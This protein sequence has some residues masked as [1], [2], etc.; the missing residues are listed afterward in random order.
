MKYLVFVLAYFLMVD[1]C[2]GQCNMANWWYSFDKNGWSLC[3]STME[4]MTGMERN[5]NRGDNDKIYLLEKAKCCQA[6][7]PN[8]ESQSTCLIADWWVKLNS[9]NKWALC[10]EGY[11][12]QGLYRTSEEDWLSNIELGKCCKPDSLPNQY[13]KC[14]DKAITSSFD[15]KGLS[16]CDDGYYMAG[17]YKGSCNRLYCIETLKCCKMYKNID[18]CV[19]N[20]CKNG[21]TCVNFAGSYRCECK[22]GYTGNNCQT[23]INE[24]ALA[25]CQNGAKCVDL[26]GSY[27]CD[28]VAGYTGSNCETNVDEC[29]TDPCK[30]GATCVDLVGSYRCDCPAGYNGSNCE[31]SIENLNF[32]IYIDE[33]APAPCQNAATCVDLVGNYRCDCVNGYSGSNCETNIDEC[34][35]APCKNGATCVDLV[36]AYRCD[37]VAGYTGSNCETGDYR[38]TTRC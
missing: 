31:T 27:R 15:N 38:G 8:R 13:G 1:I 6:P 30:N 20:P 2:W 33:C 35:P 37:C 4:Y 11:F 22:S 12:L 26:V 32:C 17:F 10:P 16:S 36:G 3:D 14:I 21:A 18:E 34:V 19:N 5:T 25:P 28:C 23:D 29:V 7:S 24:C 9:G